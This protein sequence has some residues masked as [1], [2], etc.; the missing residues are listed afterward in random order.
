MKYQCLVLDHDDTVTDSTAHIHYPAFLEAM[1]RMRPGY[2][3]TLQDYF[4]LNFDPGFL[5]YVVNTLHFTPEDLKQEEGIWD[6]FVQTRVPL[7]FPG[8]KKLILRFVNAGGHIAVISHSLAHNIRRDYRENG[9]PEPEIV[10]GWEQE[11]GHRKPDAWPL[12]QVLERLGMKPEEVLMVDDLKPG[13]D[14]A[15]K[16]GVD[17]A[18]AMWAYDVKEIRDYM[19]F[20]CENCF[21]TPGE[22]EA[23]V[24]GEEERK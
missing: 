12:E 19:R 21:L 11:Q 4:R 10:F 6:D 17:F 16:C 14:M 3:V 18:A 7:V 1:R 15:R 2:Y 5:D 23:F 13:L 24:F 9:L 22:L 8:M 20:N